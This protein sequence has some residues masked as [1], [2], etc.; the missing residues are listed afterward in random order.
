M[1]KEQNGILG[2]EYFEVESGV[3]SS[4]SSISLSSIK[5]VNL[6]SQELVDTRCFTFSNQTQMESI[7][8]QIQILSELPNHIKFGETKTLSAEKKSRIIT[9][10]KPQNCSLLSILKSNGK[11]TV[12]ETLNFVSLLSNSLKSFSPSQ[13]HLIKISL[14]TIFLQ[15]ESSLAFDFSS[16]VVRT[17]ESCFSEEFEAKRINQELAQLLLTLI[18]GKD[19][20]PILPKSF[21]NDKMTHFFRKLEKFEQFSSL[22][23]QTKNLLEKVFLGEQ[24][25]IFGVENSFTNFPINFDQISNLAPK[26]SK[27]NNYYSKVLASIHKKLASKRNSKNEVNLLF[28]KN[29]GF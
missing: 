28:G 5:A 18:I 12:N 3:I 21:T 10:F 16:S 17:E 1:K 29:L 11:F 26:L 25:I 4:S 6:K 15:S 2:C 8:D 14:Q 9:Y 22:P 20:T 7:M 24:R 19:L 13:Y 23:S 27:C